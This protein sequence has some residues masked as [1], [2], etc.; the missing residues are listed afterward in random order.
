MCDSLT[1]GK[2]SRT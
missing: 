2:Y 1:T